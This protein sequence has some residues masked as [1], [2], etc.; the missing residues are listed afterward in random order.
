MDLRGTY[1]R[2]GPNPQHVLNEKHHIFDGDGM[3]H[4]FEFSDQRVGYSNKWVRTEKFVLER[5]AG[6]SLFGGM[7]IAGEIL[8]FKI[9]LAMSQTPM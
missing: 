8:L 6:R 3:I 2:N 5:E 9:D 7:T 1:F 4:A